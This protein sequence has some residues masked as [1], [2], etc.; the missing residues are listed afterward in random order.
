MET[1]YP[2]GRTHWVPD[3]TCRETFG[4]GTSVSTPGPDRLFAPDD[5]R[6]GQLYRAV[7]AVKRRVIPQRDVLRQRREQAPKNE[8]EQIQ[9]AL[10]KVE[11]LVSATSREV[12]AN[13]PAMME[14]FWAA[15]QE[16]RPFWPGKGV[17]R[18]TA[19]PSGFSPLRIDRDV[20]LLINP[21]VGKQLLE[22]SAQYVEQ[23]EETPRPCMFYMP[24][25]ISI[26]WPGD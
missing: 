13:E 19:L 10:S 17:Q 2:S 5:V 15:Y 4:T 18:I 6:L 20:A 26:W 23:L 12:N 11:A 16:G 3:R 21:A 1:V 22:E 8:A 7:E 14:V 24:M 9:A 25:N